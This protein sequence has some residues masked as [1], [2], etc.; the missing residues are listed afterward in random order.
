MYATDRQIIERLLIP[1]LMQVVL[2][3]IRAGLGD[4]GAVLDPVSALLGEAMREPLDGLPP[5]RVAKLVRRSKRASEAAMAPLGNRLM[6]V[7][8]LAL[9]KLTAD[10]AERDVIAV[11][12]DSSFARAWD[13]MAEIIDIGDDELARLDGDAGVAAQEARWTLEGLGF[14][15]VE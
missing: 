13:M 1:A 5:E 6:G 15:R 9:A 4:D 2:T 7:Q 3:G 8:Y 10:L 12:A 11:G 14:Y